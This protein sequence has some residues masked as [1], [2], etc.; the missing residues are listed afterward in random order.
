[1][2]YEIEY[3]DGS[4]EIVET[5]TIEIIRRIKYLNCKVYRIMDYHKNL[6]DD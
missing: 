2:S 6:K 4:K 3:P 1:M 5:M